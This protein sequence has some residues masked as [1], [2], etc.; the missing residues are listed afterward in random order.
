MQPLGTG[1]KELL[2][3]PAE[4]TDTVKALEHLSYEERLWELSAEEEAES[5]SQQSIQTSP[6]DARSLVPESF[7]WCPVTG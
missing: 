4:G 1:G 5:G 6:R 3:S 2:Q 7:W